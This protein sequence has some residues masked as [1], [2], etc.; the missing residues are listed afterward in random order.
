MT[1]GLLQLLTMKRYIH[2]ARKKFSD[3]SMN[4]II[5]VRTP[6]LLD[7]FRRAINILVT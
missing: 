2:T 6:G 5:A 1:V 4:G 7:E 3:V